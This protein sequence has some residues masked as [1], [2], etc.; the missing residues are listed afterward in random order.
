MDLFPLALSL[1]VA[2]IATALTLLLGIPVALLL[3]RRRFPGRNL[4][5]AVVVLPL[6]LPPTVLGY[7]L[8]L[9]IGRRGP[10]GAALAAVGLELAFT[11]RAAV[12]AAAV[13]SI[14]LVIKSAQAGFESVDH[15]L[16]QA[17]RTLGRSEWSVFWSV[18]LPLAWR[19]VLAGAVL[20]FCRALGE[21]GITLMVA[22]NIPGRTQTL[23]LA[24]Y[25]RVQAYQMDEANALALIALGVVVVLVFGLSRLARLRY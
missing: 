23:P 5:E 21:F 16:E 20:A 1:R 7:Y 14:A 24:I 6:V 19:A 8:L 10:V 15:Q 18:T 12:L 22:G 11:W 4:L 17:A 13:G 9:L 25:D 3:A 2:L